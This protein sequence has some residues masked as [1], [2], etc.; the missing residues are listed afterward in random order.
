MS[1]AQTKSKDSVARG[2]PAARDIAEIRK[3]PGGHWV[4]DGFPVRT[5]F[6]YDNATAVS[7]FLL[8]DYAGPLNF[9]AA[10]KRRGVGE[11]P[12]RGFETVTIVYSGEVEHRDSSGGGGKIGPGDV[13][14]MTAGSG[15][16]HEEMHSADYTRKGGAF[17]AIQLWVNLPARLKMTRPQYQ[18]ILS[19]DIAEAALPE[20]AGMVRVIAGAFGDAKGPAKTFTPMNLWDVR[21]AAGKG[22]WFDVPAGYNV[23]VFLMKGDAT[24]NG[25]K[26]LGPAELAILERNGEGFRLD[27]T[28]GAHLIV[29]SGEPID[30]PV[31]GYGPFVMNSEEEIRQAIADYQS[32]KMGHLRS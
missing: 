23:S 26:A 15:L 20:G 22:A 29:L 16:V 32:G 8:F 27:S 24:I 11:H 21:L 10:E 14:W 1:M 2:L 6:G 7:P 17:E 5:I 9:P 13:Q 31:F 28:N 12:H 18:T 25:G 30:E 19:T 3:A 4:G